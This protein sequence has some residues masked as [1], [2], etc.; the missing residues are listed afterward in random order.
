[1]GRALRGMTA[2]VLDEGLR[3]VPPGAPGE[4][5]IGGVGLARGY[6]RRPGLT[7]ER[8]LPN[9]LPGAP[10]SRLYRTGDRVRLLSDGNLQFLGRLD[11]QV[12][13][14]GYRIELGEI[15]ASI[16]LIP[17]VHQ[18]AVRLLS[19]PHPRLVAYVC[20]QPQHRGD[21]AQLRRHLAARLPDYML[22]A[23][24][25]ELDAL[26][27]NHNG[28]IDRSALPAPAPLAAAAGSAPPTTPTQRA[29]AE[30]WARVIGIDQPGVHDD[31]FDLGGD[32]V[33]AVEAVEE[34]GRLLGVTI[35][36]RW[37]FEHPTIATL[38]ELLDERPAA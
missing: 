10:G 30:V 12:K 3:P 11:H 34:S 16:R 17:G 9:P 38:A 24:W 26:P 7:A 1:I 5:C 8:F 27:T 35:R 14:R 15:E 6:L 29:L 25:V 28:K 19:D 33:L 21:L 2:H 20:R 4:L 22:P 13:L 31:F 23:A 32:S 18:A 37:L 36:P